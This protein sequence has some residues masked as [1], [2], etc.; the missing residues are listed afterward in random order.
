MGNLL[1]QQARAAVTEAVQCADTAQKQEL[2]EKAKNALLS[3]YANSSTA[4]KVQLR[5]MQQ[6]L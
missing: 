4:E 3:A 5:N 6:Q 1:F 2:T